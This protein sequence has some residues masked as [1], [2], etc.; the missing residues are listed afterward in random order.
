MDLV[1]LVFDR[2]C[3]AGTPDDKQRAAIYQ[4][5]R[6]LVAAAHDDTAERERALAALEKVIRRQEMQALYEQTLQ[7]KPEP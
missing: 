7:R 1:R 5:C 2:L 3:A 4:D 6:A